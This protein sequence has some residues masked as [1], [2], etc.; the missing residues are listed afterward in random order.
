MKREHEHQSL[1]GDVHLKKADSLALVHLRNSN[2][3]V[4]ALSVTS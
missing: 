3:E 4:P 1:G 2:A